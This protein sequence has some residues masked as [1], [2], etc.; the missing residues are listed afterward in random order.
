MK[1]E[2]AAFLFTLTSVR[3]LVGTFILYSSVPL[4]SAAED[5]VEVEDE[6]KDKAQAYF[7]RGEI[8][9]ENGEYLKAAE[10]FSLAYETLPAPAVLA[11][12]GLAYE[13]AGAY[14]KAVERYRQCLA[15]FEKRGEKNPRIETRLDE[16]QGKVAELEVSVLCPGRS[17]VVLIDSVEY[18]TVPVHAFVLPGEHSLMAVQ[19]GRILTMEKITVEPREIAEV[20]L[21]KKERGEKKQIETAQK[22]GP[23][24]PISP[25]NAAEKTKPRAAASKRF[26]VPLWISTG[27]AVGTGIASAILWGMTAATKNEFDQADALSEAKELKEGGE[28][29]NTAAVVT[30]SVAGAATAAAVVL[31]SIRHASSERRTA[32]VSVSFDKGRVSLE[33]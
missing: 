2:S 19:D 32:S 11:N 33:F 24:I 17:C 25:Q 6:I 27:V 5:T 7:D 12:I 29:L 13:Q 30:I 26:G 28:N 22:S 4:S 23:P 14:H 15:E 21:L 8:L 1:I 3:T 18:K 31:A 9:F 20:V 10:A 16:L